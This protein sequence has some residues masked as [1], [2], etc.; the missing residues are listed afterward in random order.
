[1]KG[2]AMDNETE[3]PEFTFYADHD[4]W[5]IKIND[6]GI[7]FNHEKWPNR[8]PE[9]FAQAFIDILEKCYDVTFTKRFSDG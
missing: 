2:L 5:V 6:D 7:F 8:K 3:N 1:M 9:H 4:K